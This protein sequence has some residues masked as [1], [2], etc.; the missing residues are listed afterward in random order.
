MALELA[1]TST[2]SRSSDGADHFAPS[3]PAIHE[4]PTVSNSAA[5]D[6][7]TEM[8]ASTDSVEF[9]KCMGAFPA[10]DLV[11]LWAEVYNAAFMDPGWAATVLP[12]LR[13]RVAQRAQ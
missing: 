10:V 5:T 9:E 4:R 7:T 8:T 12:R 1:S 13:R 6:S 2:S 11:G 3:R